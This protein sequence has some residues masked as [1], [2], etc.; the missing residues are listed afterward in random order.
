MMMNRTKGRQYD[1]S[2]AFLILSYVIH[3]ISIYEKQGMNCRIVVFVDN[4]FSWKILPINSI[5]R[6]L[7]CL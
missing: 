7:R 5:A 4:V 1:I 2:G 6:N 3:Y